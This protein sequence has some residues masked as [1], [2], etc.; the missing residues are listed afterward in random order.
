MFTPS[1]RL[2]GEFLRYAAIGT[3]GLCSRSHRRSGILPAPGMRGKYGAVSMQSRGPPQPGRFVL[4]QPKLARRGGPW[5]LQIE[6]EYSPPLLLVILSTA[7]SRPEAFSSPS[8]PVPPQDMGNPAKSETLW[9]EEEQGS[10]RSFRRRR[11]RSRAD[12]ATPRLWWVYPPSPPSLKHRRGRLSRGRN[13]P[14]L[15]AACP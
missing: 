14:S 13:A 4:R 11:K 9:G 15:A 10:G 3:A 7:P 2:E 12:F 5:P 6:M 8:F 1:H